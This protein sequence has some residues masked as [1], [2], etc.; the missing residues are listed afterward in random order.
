MKLLP[1]IITDGPGQ[2]KTRRDALVAAVVFCVLT[3]AVS[4]FRASL[5]PDIA[6]QLWHAKRMMLI[7]AGSLVFWL[8]IIGPGSGK[9]GL[10][11]FTRMA[12]LGL[13]GIAALFTLAIGWDMLVSHETDDMVAWN[14]RWMVLWTGYFSAG[15]SAWL[16][17]RFG[18]ALAHAERQ[19]AVADSDHAAR[20]ASD[21][22]FWVKTGQQT[23]CIPHES[24]E[25]IEAEGNY[26]R[27]HAIDGAHGLIRST[28]SAIEAELD[29]GEFQRIH[30]SALCRRSA[31][32]GYRRQRSG[33]MRALLASGAEVPL[34]R[35]YASQVIDQSRALQGDAS[36]MDDTV[37][38][39][40]SLKP[41]T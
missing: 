35:S 20:P 23:I 30:R 36:V 2:G 11:A 18:T 5:N 16:A 7:G 37:S 17:I 12:M 6:F 32:R 31:I 25:W 19:M 28:L 24:V 1:R 40:D 21:G 10:R 26:V 13:P 15:L 38:R 22:G 14:L 4:S 33:A 41:T 34:G 29:T 39:R 3:F 27:I 8:A 9:P